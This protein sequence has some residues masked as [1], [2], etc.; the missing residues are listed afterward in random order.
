MTK[1][2]LLLEI[3]KKHL[4]LTTLDERK[5]DQLDFH[6]VAVWSIK[7]ALEAAFDAGSR[8]NTCPEQV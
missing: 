1:Q 5:S 3:A 4:G 8:S 2:Q 6:T 7:D